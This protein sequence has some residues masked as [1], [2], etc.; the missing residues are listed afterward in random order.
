MDIGAL[1]IMREIAKHVVDD[2][3]TALQLGALNMH[4]ITIS[5]SIGVS[6]ARHERGRNP[7]GSSG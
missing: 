6:A 3:I 1:Y 5:D 4:S 7:I 2:R